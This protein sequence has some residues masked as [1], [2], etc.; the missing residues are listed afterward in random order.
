[1]TIDENQEFAPVGM[2]SSKETHSDHNVMM[3]K[4]DWLV[5][6]KMQGAK[7]K[8]IITKRGYGGIRRDLAERKVSDIL[9]NSGDLQS[10]YEEWKRTVTLV[11]KSNETVVKAKNPRKQIKELIRQKKELKRKMKRSSKKEREILIRRV[12]Q[13]DEQITEENNNQFQ[14]KIE[15]VVGEL[16]S[17]KGING[18]NMW[19][20][21]K[22]VKRKIAEP[23][24]AIKDEEGKILEET[25]AIKSRYLEH[26]EDILQPPVAAGKEEQD[27]EE[28]VNSAF[29]NIMKIAKKQPTAL[30]AMAEIEEAIKE[31]KKKK[32]KD[33]WGWNN[34]IVIEGGKEMIVSLK[35]LFNRMERE[36]IAPKMWNDVTI[37]AVH[38]K[39]S[40]LEMDNKRGLFITEII[41]KVYEKVLKNRNRKKIKNL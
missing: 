22:R 19:E 29:E 5:N 24:T 13:I 14:N 39:G 38:K 23:P 36:R 40:V 1:M 33:E 15:K 27:Q 12:K 17:E 30:T 16:R 6:V 3:A 20:V 35:K 34:E 10:C 7:G 28:F 25:E 9:D 4:W 2:E 18:P 37:K 11:M 26:F 8:S 32:C 21:L 41:S 31:L